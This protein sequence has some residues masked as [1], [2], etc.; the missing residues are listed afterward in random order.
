MVA[1]FPS[2]EDA[3]DDLS[4][5]Y[6][7]EDGEGIA[8]TDF[9]YTPLTETVS[10]LRE[11]FRGRSDVYVSGA[12]L[13]Y[14]RKNDNATRVSVDVLAVFGAKG[15][16]P[17]NSWLAWREGKTPDFVMEIAHEDTW[18]RDVTEKRDIYASIGVTE[19]WR[20][21]PTGE[22]FTPALAGERLADG[23]YQEIL[24]ATSDAGILG[25]RSAVLG[26]DV[27]VL[28][29]LDLRLYDPV[30]R[31]WLRTHLEN[32]QALRAAK[33]AL[34]ATEDE[35]WRL[36]EQIRELQSRGAVP[37]SGGLA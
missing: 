25:G 16:H 27:C 35:T 4:I 18:R 20:F 37:F 10:T 8:E 34:W 19:Y 30:R 15:N 36:R 33:Q 23:E 14:Y 31:G 29:G 17:R 6:P 21:D 32:E 1:E 3:E 5:E 24:L 12:K 13:L 7:S 22:C 11:R 26:L 9:Q 28:P 2:Y